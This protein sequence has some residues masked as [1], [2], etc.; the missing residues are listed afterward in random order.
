MNCICK[1]QKKM[2]NKKGNITLRYCKQE[3]KESFGIVF[4]IAVVCG[5]CCLVLDNAEQIPFVF[6]VQGKNALCVTEYLENALG[7]G[8]YSIF[9]FAAVTALPY[10]LGYH[11]DEKAG[12]LKNIVC[13]TGVQ[14]YCAGKMIAVFC[15]SF[16]A[17]FCSIGFFG[18]I[19]RYFIPFVTPDFM[20]YEADIPFMK[21]AIAGY[22]GLYF[23]LRCFMLGLW[24]GLY[25]LIVMSIST[26]IKNAEMS[27]T[28]AVVLR[29]TVNLLC[30]VMNID[31]VYR[32]AIWFYTD[33]SPVSDGWL[34]VISAVFIIVAIG[35]LGIVFKKR[36]NEKVQNG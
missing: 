16:L 24:C 34:L 32:P 33:A 21:I 31:G 30:N 12:I 15:S 7:F 26:I 13:R 27:I 19:L 9:A 4:F 28:F 10:G 29:F 5:M 1:Q 35:I 20:R 11:R 2:K 18:L 6:T 25:G 3:L 36:V 17:G 14:G 22:P 23:A 8:F